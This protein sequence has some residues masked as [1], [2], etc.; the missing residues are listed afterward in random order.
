MLGLAGNDTLIGG[1]GNDALFG[2][3]GA[4]SLI[5]GTG[6]DYYEIDNAGDVITEN[7][8]EGDDFVRSTVSWT[9]GS[10]LERLAVDGTDNLTVTGN[11][12]NNGLWGNLGNNTL[13]GSTGDDYLYGDEGNDVYVYNPGDGQDSIDNTDALTATDTLR[14]GAGIS[15]TNV[16]AFQSGANM[17]LKV[18][19]TTDQVGFINYYGANTVTN[20]VTQDHKIDRVE[21]ANGVV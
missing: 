14:F 6:D 3:E 16:L 7:S 21:F 4:D 15:D 19:G 11:S 8:N 5:G 20:G 13:T 10:N 12:L 9:L 2:S 17:F 1:A 18:K